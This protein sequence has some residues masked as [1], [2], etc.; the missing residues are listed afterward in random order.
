MKKIA[1]M[2]VPGIADKKISAFNVAG[3]RMVYY[4]SVRGINID[5]K[6]FLHFRPELC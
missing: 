5:T 1:D 2:V 3:R 4:F 6:C